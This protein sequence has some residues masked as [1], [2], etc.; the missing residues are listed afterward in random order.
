MVGILFI[1][2]CGGFSIFFNFNEF[3]WNLT[4]TF[5]GILTTI[6]YLLSWIFVGSFMGWKGRKLFN[7]VITFY[8]GM[9]ILAYMIG[10]NFPRSILYPTYAFMVLLCF[11][12][13]Y[14]LAYHLSIRNYLVLTISLAFIPWM[15]GL[16]SY[17]IGKYLREYQNR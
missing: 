12:P 17:F 13:L 7:L 8:W 1:F 15:L 16:L 10:S 6:V 3:L 4:P 14:G 9:G 11:G 5:L 2:I